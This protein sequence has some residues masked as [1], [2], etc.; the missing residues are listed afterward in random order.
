MPLQ[1][2]IPDPL[3]MVALIA[4]VAILPFFALLVTSY[5]KIVV[6]L[7]LLR[8]ALGVQQV[9][10]N[11][12]LNGIA[13]ILTA[14]V[15]APLGSQAMTA[16]EGKLRGPPQQRTFA[17][18]NVILQSVSSPLRGFLYKHTEDKNRKFFTQSAGKLWPAEDAAKVKE[19]DMLVL[20]PSFTVSELTKAFEIGFVIYLAFVV[21]DLVIANI[22]LA[23]GMSMV[24]PTVISVP[25]KLLLFVVLHGWERLAQG[26][27]LSY[28]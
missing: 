2:S 14:Y 28:Q 25:F 9:P 19:D 10:P 5:T 8:Q 16:I 4:A 21:V 7:G 15:M 18:V 27:V 24:S 13:L 11:M 23:L 3:L 1:T 26:L 20:I 17:D 12:V 6:V 22:L